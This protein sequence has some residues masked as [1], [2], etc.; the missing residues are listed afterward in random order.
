MTRRTKSEKE[1]YLDG[2]EMCAECVESYLPHAGRENLRRL[3]E[4]VKN[5]LEEDIAPQ[6]NENRVRK[7]CYYNDGEVHAECVCCQHCEMCS[8][9]D[10]LKEGGCDFFDD[11]NK[12]TPV[13]E[14]LPKKNM[15]CLVSVGGFH[16]TQIAMYSDLMGTI[17]HKIFYRGDYG[18][19]DFMNITRYVEAWMPL[20]KPYEPQEREGEG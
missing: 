10:S 7:D 3:L 4:V 20:P 15:P 2:F 16:I 13:R 19:E 9:Q 17:N 1:A 5:A 8:W 12:W 11:G 6:E 18:H 14:G